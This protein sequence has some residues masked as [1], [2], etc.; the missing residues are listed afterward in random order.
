MKTSRLKISVP[1][2][3]YPT[4]T[5]HITDKINYNFTFAYILLY[6]AFHVGC[7]SINPVSKF[8]IMYL[9]VLLCIYMG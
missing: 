9:V 2:F 3:I 5:S 8:S 1:P 7:N 4:P 6:Q